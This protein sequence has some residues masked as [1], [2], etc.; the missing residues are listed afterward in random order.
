MPKKEKH[1]F[2]RYS[3]ERSETADSILTKLVTKTANETVDDAGKQIIPNKDILTDISN[4]IVSN[5]TDSAAIFEVHPDIELAMQVLTSSIIS[6]K[7][8]LSTELSYSFKPSVEVDESTSKV[9]TIIEDYFENTY[10]LQKLLPKIL[11]DAL[12]HT[13]SYPLMILP[14]SSIDDIINSDQHVTMESI[15]GTVDKTGAI[16]SIGLLGKAGVSKEEDIGLESFFTSVVETPPL[17]VAE[18]TINDFTTITDNLDILKLPSLRTKMVQSRV[19][20]KLSVSRSIST[21]AKKDKSAYSVKSLYRERKYEKSTVIPIKPVE[22]DT[23]NKGHPLVMKL[24]SEAV[25]PVHT[26]GTPEDHVGYFILLDKTG[27]PINKSTEATQYKNLRSNISANTSGASEL[28]QQTR[29]AMVGATSESSNDVKVGEMIASYT[30]LI[31]S[32]LI[33][34]LQNGVYGD[35]ATIS[36]PEQVYHIMMSRALSRMHTQILFVP[37]ELLTYIAFNYDKD[38][39]GRSL[40]DSSKIISSI[41][42]MLLFSNTMAALKNSMPRTGVDITLDAKDP[43]PGK[44]VEILMAAYVKNHHETFPLGTNNLNDLVTHLQKSAVDV[45]VSGNTGYPDT[46]VEVNDKQ[47]SM[48]TVDTDLA[49]DMKNKQIM[50]FGLAPETI[51]ATMDVEFAT[52]LVGSNLLLAKRVMLYQS[53]LVGFLEDFVK[54]FTLNSG[55]LMQSISSAISGDEDESKVISLVESICITLPSPDTAKLSNQMEAF[56]AYTEALDNTLEAYFSEDMFGNTLDSELEDGIEPVRIA[57]RGYFQRQWLRKNNVMSELD[58]MSGEGKEEFDIFN[59]HTTHISAI[60]DSVKEL[61]LANR[62]AGR[63]TAGDI[64]KDEEDEAAAEEARLAKLEEEEAAREVEVSDEPVEETDEEVSD[65]PVEETDEEVVVEPDVPED[66]SGD[67]ELPA[68]PV[69]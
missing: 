10:P 69:T 38:G 52:S 4:N 30:S 65:E 59:V 28:L 40:L 17:S 2:K 67:D 13:G 26:P 9:I 14:E 6:P 23:E 62:K 8:M 34:R 35:S 12:F 27:N 32:T 7:D 25:I 56:T 55:P 44:T 15:S 24:P 66:T 1:D 19:A 16:K 20:D 47:R 3:F 33:Q 63:E 5:N 61:L 41:R 68:P 60:L 22:G 64:V 48:A 39:V 45:N 54:K 36:N 57:L 49:D 11:Q 37:A 51:D 46:K 58:I 50:S 21:E 18:Q 42:S 31:E 53:Q 29:Q 43:N